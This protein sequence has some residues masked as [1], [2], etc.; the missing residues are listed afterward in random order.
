MCPS[1]S[2]VHSNPGS[3]LTTRLIVGADIESCGSNESCVPLSTLAQDECIRHNSQQP[4]RPDAF[5]VFRHANSWGH[6]PRAARLAPRYREIN[7]RPALDRARAYERRPS[8]RLMPKYRQYHR[9]IV[10]PP[11]FWCD[12][13]CVLCIASD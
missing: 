7:A 13:V 10:S 8:R 2:A 1:G 5:R 3:A 6:R 11:R 9:L 12:G 4:V